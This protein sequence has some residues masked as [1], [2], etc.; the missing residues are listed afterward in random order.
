MDSGWRA[1]VSGRKQAWISFGG[2]G[3]AAVLVVI[4]AWMSRDR[5]Q[6]AEPG[7]K[8]PDFSALDLKGTPTSLE[9]FRGTVVLLNIWATWCAPCKEEMPSIQR[10]FEKVPDADFRVLAV[11]ID[12]V[13]SDHDPKDPLGGK[14]RA[15]AD[16]LGLT[17]TI[18]HDPT[19]EISDTYR[20]TGVPESFILDREG[21]IRKKVTGPMAWDAPQNVQFINGLLE[22]KSNPHR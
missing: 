7:A 14:L 22:R 16:S 15:F 17:F 13:G 19:G 8:A 1:K 5:L 12:R 10:L 2:A 3:L 6:P 9:A 4:L 21:V 11:S 20:T 18:L